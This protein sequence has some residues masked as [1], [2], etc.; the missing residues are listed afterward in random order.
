M[1]DGATTLE[2]L[3]PVWAAALDTAEELCTPSMTLLGAAL[4][5][6][7]NATLTAV[8]DTILTIALVLGEALDEE[9][10]ADTG[11]GALPP[12]S[13]PGTAL[14]KAVAWEGQK[15]ISKPTLSAWHPLTTWLSFD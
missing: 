9:G 8:L 5:E 12:D 10:A 6:L 3:A 7:V 4:I 2:T 15:V 11:T 13:D 1:E 14:V